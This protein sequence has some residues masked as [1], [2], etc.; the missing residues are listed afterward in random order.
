[1]QYLIYYSIPLW[2]V[3]FTHLYVEKILNGFF[4]IGILQKAVRSKWNSFVILKECVLYFWQQENEIA[5]E[6]VCSSTSYRLEAHSKYKAY[7]YKD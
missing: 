1:M 4:F 3:F 7:P 6:Y 5:V 2:I